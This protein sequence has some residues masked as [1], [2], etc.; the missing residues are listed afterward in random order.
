VQTS[1]SAG[2]VDGW[3]MAVSG[4]GFT[5]DAALVVTQCASEATS[6]DECGPAYV[7]LTADAEGNYSTSWVASRFL[8][9]PAL[10]PVDCAEYAGRC[11]V[12]ALE[13]GDVATAV[14]VGL[15]FGTVAA[16]PDADLVD[17]QTVAVSGQGFTPHATLAVTQCAAG[18]MSESDCSQSYVLVDADAAGNY[19]ASLV[20]QRNLVTNGIGTINCA[21]SVGRCVVVAVE[22]ADLATAVPTA[23]GFRPNPNLAA[24]SD[25]V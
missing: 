1:R 17:Q 4:G 19:S 15:G 3:E 13:D 14:T 11:M 10:G 2:L 6:A 23:I 12:V 21:V 8:Q 18:P 9:T 16:S 5:P 7:T 22:I 24:A 20:V 25:A